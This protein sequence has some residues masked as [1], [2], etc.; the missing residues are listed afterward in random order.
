M[1]GFKRVFGSFFNY[2][3]RSLLVRYFL[4]GVVLYILPLIAFSWMVFR[5]S[6]KI[7]R[8]EIT[9]LAVSNLTR[10]SELF[11]ELFVEANYVAAAISQLPEISLFLEKGSANSSVVNSITKVMKTFVHTKRFLYNIYIYSET[12]GSV[13]TTT[14]EY[15]IPISLLEDNGW[16]TSYEIHQ[17]LYPFRVARPAPDRKSSIVSVVKTL[18]GMNG[19]RKDGAIIVNFN[20]DDLDTLVALDPS[21]GVFSAF[22]S[23]AILYTNT[24]SRATIHPPEMEDAS[25]RIIETVK[26]VSVHASNVSAKTDIIYLQDLSLTRFSTRIAAVRNFTISLAFISLTGALFTSAILAWSNYTPIRRLLSILKAPDTVSFSDKRS[27]EVRDI[28]AGLV[29]T[30]QTNRILREELN[31]RLCLLDRTKTAALQA[32]INPHFLYNTL[33]SIRWEAMELTGQENKVTDM[34]QNLA[35]LL[36][37]SMEI[38][39]SSVTVRQEVEHACMFIRL[40][41]VRYPKKFEVIWHVDDGLMD[42]RILKLSLQPLIENAFSHGVKPLKR[43]GTI[44]IDASE[45]E[46]CLVFR[47]RDDGKGILPDKLEAIR[48]TLIDNRA[49]DSEHIGLANVNARIKLV[50]GPQYGLEIDSIPSTGTTVTL[51][52]P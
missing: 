23:G 6:D 8:E 15:P 48:E 25:P 24:D 42:R 45:E 13:L 36:R 51:R 1:K 34:L 37:L 50:F 3:F 49:V 31:D 28:A 12:D 20:S 27:D 46:N 44:F 22:D 52:M 40:L 32:Q 7:V 18:Y 17:D 33:D 41:K 30:I 16:L 19:T 5:N 47:V 14:K 39:E 10:T 9:A 35:R 21:Q 26:G 4:L 2:R 38:E 29:R 43:M 11:D